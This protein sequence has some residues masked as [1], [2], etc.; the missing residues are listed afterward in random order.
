MQYHFYFLSLFFSLIISITGMS[1]SGK[2]PCVFK[3]MCSFKS[4]ANVFQ[5]AGAISCDTLWISYAGRNLGIVK[6]SFKNGPYRWQDRTAKSLEEK[7]LLLAHNPR[8]PG[9]DCHLGSVGQGKLREYIV[10]MA[11]DRPLTY[12]HAFPNLRFA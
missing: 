9:K 5:Q 11:L 7:I 6:N 3:L 8:T 2:T 4:S 1:Q 12:Y 10:D